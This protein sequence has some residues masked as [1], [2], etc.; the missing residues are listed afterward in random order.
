MARR[1]NAEGTASAAGF[2]LLL[3]SIM[4]LVTLGLDLLIGLV[5]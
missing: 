4:A 3:F 1:N 2:L 5:R